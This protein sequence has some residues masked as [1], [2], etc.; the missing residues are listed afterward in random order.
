MKPAWDQ[1]MKD[2][3]GSTT[4]LV[5]DVDCTVEESL[6]SE[7][8]VEGY[9]TIKY[10]DPAS[11]QDYQG[12]RELDDLTTFAKENLGP[13]CGPSNLDLC[14]D[15]QKKAIT[16][17]QAL[18]D[19]EI[20]DKLKEKH[21]QMEAAETAYKTEVDALQAKYEQ[22]SKDKDAKIAEIKKGDL[23]LLTTL[24]KERPECTPPAPPA[25]SGGEEEG[26]YGE[27]DEDL[28]DDDYGDMP[29]DADDADEQ[30]P[31]DEDDAKDEM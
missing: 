20:Q 11:L 1:L 12:G 4:A 3:E 17:A 25:G 8:G 23:S 6:C 7:H 29:D 22:I 16:E 31:M 15:E 26:D 9:P 5:A 14:D 27:G 28:G 21:D 30:P 13:V 10:G 19:T 24:C 2:F 18:S